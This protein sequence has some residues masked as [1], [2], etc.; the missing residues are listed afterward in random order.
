MSSKE[1]ILSRPAG[2]V[3]LPLYKIAMVLLTILYFFSKE[4]DARFRSVVIL[5][6]GVSLAVGVVLDL[7]EAWQRRQARQ[8]LLRGED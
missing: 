1:E 8:S 2:L 3:S 4:F 5:V 7:K 6:L